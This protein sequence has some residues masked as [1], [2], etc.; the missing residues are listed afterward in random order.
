M[1]LGAPEKKDIIQ[2][3]EGM[4]V[5]ILYHHA[6]NDRGRRARVSKGETEKSIQKEGD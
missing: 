5:R 2:D 1:M 3:V 4:G 6:G